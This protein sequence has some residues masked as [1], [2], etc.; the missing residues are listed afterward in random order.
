MRLNLINKQKIDSY[1]MN[2]SCEEITYLHETYFKKPKEAI[3]YNQCCKSDNEQLKSEKE[4]LPYAEWKA[5]LNM[6]K[7][8]DTIYKIGTDYLTINEILEMYEEYYH[9]F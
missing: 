7:V 9:S 4:P 1:F 5:N 8:E 2:L 3:N 6:Q